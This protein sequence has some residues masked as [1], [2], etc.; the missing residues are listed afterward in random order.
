MPNGIPTEVRPPPRPEWPRC[1]LR[2]HDGLEGIP[3]PRRERVRDIAMFDSIHCEDNNA[4]ESPQL[5][6]NL[7]GSPQ[8]SSSQAQ[9]SAPPERAL[10]NQRGDQGETPLAQKGCGLAASPTHRP[11]VPHP[12][13]GRPRSS[14][15][16]P[17]LGVGPGSWDAPAFHRIASSCEQAPATLT[18]VSPR[19]GPD[20]LSEGYWSLGSNPV[21]CR[22]RCH[23]FLEWGH[24]RSRTESSSWPTGSPAK[25]RPNPGISVM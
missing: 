1:R 24:C 16:K 8:F 3:Q 7:A 15:G 21:S 6:L 5:E 13:S 12:E 19:R 2:N 11:V 4:H 14:R 18:P 22:G 25:R 10:A 23:H 17:A 9:R 20:P